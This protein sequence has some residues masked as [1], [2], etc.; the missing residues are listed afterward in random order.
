MYL[1]KILYVLG[2][3]CIG[4]MAFETGTPSH[5]LSSDISADL[6]R[7]ALLPP[8][9]AWQEV[10]AVLA[11]RLE[12][13]ELARATHESRHPLARQMADSVAARVRAALGRPLGS[14]DSRWTHDEEALA[15]IPPLRAYLSLAE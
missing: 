15:L 13:L 10:S 2:L 9:Q 1:F 3:F 6:D 12:A 7:I 4:D 11:I 8:G 14:G 5:G